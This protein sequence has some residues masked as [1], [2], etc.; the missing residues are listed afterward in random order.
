MIFASQCRRVHIFWGSVCWFGMEAT[1]ELR[2]A[3]LDLPLCIDLVS[4]GAASQ[5]R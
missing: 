1:G 5:S 2:L 3:K 4:G